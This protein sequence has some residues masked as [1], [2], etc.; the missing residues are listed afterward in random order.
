MIIG[1]HGLARGAP[2]GTRFIMVFI[3]GVVKQTT[4]LIDITEKFN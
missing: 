3:A 4:I 2:W 1:D